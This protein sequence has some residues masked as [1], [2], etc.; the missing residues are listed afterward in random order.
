MR[1]L[2][3]FLLLFAGA[4]VAAAQASTDVILRT[5]GA[6]IPGRVL[7]ITPVAVTYLP[8]G[9][10]SPD[11]LRLANADVFLIRYANGTREVLRS[12][13]LTVP[14]GPPDLLPGLSITQ[15]AELGRA[16]AFYY[17]D[18]GPFW[19]AL[20]AT[21]YG[22]PLLGVVAPAAIAPH[23]V[24]THN[25]AAPTPA[26]LADPVYNRAYR[27]EALRRKRGRAWS[28]Y[29]AGTGVWLVLIGSLAASQ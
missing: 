7:T 5:D 28:G 21:L 15:R 26:L 8:A 17:T 18:R 12:M 19:G 22:G 3:L 16:A 25:L 20:G 1:T 4:R 6:E 29:A 11:T 23:A 14:A 10:S 24:K 2:L 13:A 27:S 9:P